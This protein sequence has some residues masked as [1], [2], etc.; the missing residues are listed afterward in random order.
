MT[1]VRERIDILGSLRFA[2][3]WTKCVTVCWDAIATRTTH[4]PFH[5]GTFFFF[6]LFIVCEFFVVFFFFSQFRHKSNENDRCP[7]YFICDNVIIRIEQMTST[8][9]QNGQNRKKRMR[10]DWM[11]HWIV[12]CLSDFTTPHHRTHNYIEQSVFIC[13]VDSVLA[14]MK[15]IV[16]TK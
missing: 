8:T 15:F 7:S 4:I 3:R 1:T 12:L 6:R 10:D 9:R 14:K 11:T 16:V 5:F 2:H 13:R